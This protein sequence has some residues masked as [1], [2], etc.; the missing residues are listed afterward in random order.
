MARSLTQKKGGSRASVKQI[1][2]LKKPNLSGDGDKRKNT[3][4]KVRFDG[5]PSD[6]EDE[7]DMFGG[8]K[9]RIGFDSEE[10]GSEDSLFDEEPVFDLPD[11]DE[12][13]E[14][15]E[16]EEVDANDSDEEEE[17]SEETSENDQEKS[18]DMSDEE[19]L[20]SADSN[21]ED[22]TD[23]KWGKKRKTYYDADMDALEE[24]AEEA[25]KLQKKKL[26]NMNR[27]DF[28]L[29][30]QSKFTLTGPITL[31]SDS[32]E[33]D[34]GD[35]SEKTG[36]KEISEDLSELAEEFQE[37][38]RQV[39]Q[40]LEPFI[41]QSKNLPR[42][43]GLKFLSVKYQLLTNYCSFLLK[44][45]QL[46]VA[47]PKNKDPMTTG[48]V[49]ELI[50]HRLLIEKL[51][52]IEL[53]LKHQIDTL[54]NVKPNETILRPGMGTFEDD[55]NGVDNKE[56]D[57]HEG[58]YKVPKVNP[59]HFP[60]ENSSKKKD[61]KKVKFP[62]L[63]DGFESEPEEEDF[64]TAAT[65]NNKNKSANKE[66]AEREV[67]EEENFVRFTLSKT[68]K[69]RLMKASKLNDEL[70][71][72][73]DFMD[74]L[75]DRS[76]KMTQQKQHST[77]GHSSSTKSLSNEASESSMSEIEDD[78]AEEINSQKKLK[79]TRQKPTKKTSYLPI[80]DMSGKNI[81]RLA[82]KQILKNRGL[83]VNRPKDIK[84]P[85]I[86]Q[87]RKFERAIKRLP[88]LH[89][90]AKSASNNFYGGESSGIRTNIS[91]STKFN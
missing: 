91:K 77:Q 80:Q 64:N 32:D 16:N 10:E 24:E 52:P 47:T 30:H 74:E 5:I 43:Q 56:E 48:L 61:Q 14:Y 42:S 49:D 40:V 38:L 45:L 67:Y 87:R 1:S 71:D 89:P 57:S 36:K 78:I 81:D 18:D 33:S 13:L 15:D 34:N 86:K 20:N 37:N 44:Y 69:T 6:L 23:G 26:A 9:D 82:S 50:R 2:I 11:E 76:R 12:D 62:E 21:S 79:K 39:K 68:D 65:S 41:Q 54:L 25:E 28:G 7:D 19:I 60:D 59:V 8:Q 63:E 83:T 73:D 85:R 70:D 66:L 90:V 31:Q 35:I 58:T 84:N 88:S 51:K 27:E 4:K 17:D 55:E 75:E 46:K 3:K 53:T 22:E 29:R 72:L